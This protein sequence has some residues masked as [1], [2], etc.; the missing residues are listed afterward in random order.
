M[1]GNSRLSHWF[2]AVYLALAGMPDVKGALRLAL[3]VPGRTLRALRRSGS[4]KWISR[5]FG[6]EAEYARFAAELE[7][8]G[9]LKRLLA[10]LEVSFNGLTGAT[11]TG[12][13]YVS[14]AI[15]RLHAIHLYALV[16]RLR[17]DRMLETGVC[18]GLSS[19]VILR[20]MQANGAGRLSSVD[21]PEFSGERGGAQAFW[22]GKG[23]AVVPAGLAPG[24]L[25]PQELRSRWDLHLGRSASLLP[26]L[27]DELGP[28]DCFLHDSEH[29]FENQSFE[30]EAAARHLRPGGILV[31]SDTGASSA[32]D[33][34]CAAHV[35]D[36][37]VYWV[38]HSLALA[39]KR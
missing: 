1:L 39:L 13:P 16:R 11:A 36:F 20:A 6:T 30:F 38:D 8:S 34:F 33:A 15:K 23:G 22:S 27:L 17:P 37:E 3:R 29:S 24:W 9:E 14:G 35:C 32:F 28:I 26:P 12:V 25:V 4:R 10:A 21:L 31:A 18:N 19:A 7:G 5:I 2:R